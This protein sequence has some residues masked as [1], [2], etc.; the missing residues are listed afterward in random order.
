MSGKQS[1]FLELVWRKEYEC[2]HPTVDVQ[3]RHLFKL[4]NS[5]LDAV[6][7][8]QP[9]PDIERALDAFIDDVANHFMSEEQA[10]EEE[11]IGVAESHREKHRQLLEKAEI[12]RANFGEGAAGASEVLSFVV[13]DIIDGHIS[14]EDGSWFALL[15]N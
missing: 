4:G 1:G 9:K 13:Y 10:L 8:H 14:N 7:T 3:H 2:G 15:K 5:L 12:L 11:H 6:L